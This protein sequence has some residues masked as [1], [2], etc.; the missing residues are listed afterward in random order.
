MIKK[1]I[2]PIAGRG[3]R[4]LPATKSISK[5]MLPIVN[6]PT[7]MLLVEECLHSGIEEIIF[8]VGEHNHELLKNFFTQNANLNEFLK[9][10]PKKEL[11][12]EINTIIDQIKF[13]F[14]FQDENVRGTAGAI[15]AARNLIKD[16]Y[17]AVIYGDDLIDAEIPALKQLITEH[18]RHTC[19]VIGVGTVPHELV[20]NYGV[21]AY[22]ED[23]IVSGIIEKPSIEEAPSNHVL[24]G[25]LILNSTIF[26]QILTCPKHNN[27][28]YYLPEALMSLNEEIRALKYQGQYYDIGNKLGY[29]KAN[30]A[31]G[32]KDQSI[33]EDLLKYLENYKNNESRN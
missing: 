4:F 29:I 23:N 32:L 14:V 16:E 17:F 15:Y 8:V 9:N 21:V 3:T 7:I 28:E 12:N 20:S 18:E 2:I 24:Q 11:L 13:H 10:D 26:S 5:E 6:R 31:Y 25:R 33:K 27:N 22:R 19:N 30:I 1:C